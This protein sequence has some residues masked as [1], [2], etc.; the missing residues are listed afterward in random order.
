MG[1]ARSKGLRTATFKEKLFIKVGSEYLPVMLIMNTQGSRA[2]KTAEFLMG[3]NRLRK[4]AT[5]LDMPVPQ[6]L[7]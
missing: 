3:F 1:V 6:E 2:N 7:K 4:Y 5:G